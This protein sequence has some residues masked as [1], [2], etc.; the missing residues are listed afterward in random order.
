MLSA[1]RGATEI[2]RKNTG[3]CS[4]VSFL[5]DAALYLKIK[6][7]SRAVQYR[8]TPGSGL[9]A[10][11]LGDSFVVQY[12][13]HFRFGFICGSMWG[14]LAVRDRLGVCSA[15]GGPSVCVNFEFK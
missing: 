5:K 15:L 7:L 9:L 6:E 11:Q 2:A 10:V 3:C 14:S 12:G 4:F 13:D 8:I 1:S